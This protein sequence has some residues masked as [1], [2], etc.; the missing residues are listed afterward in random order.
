MALFSEGNLEA[1]GIKLDTKLR[2]CSVCGTSLQ[3]IAG[4]GYCCPNGH[5]CWWPQQDEADK[6]YTHPAA[7]YRGG[8]VVYKGNSKGRKR[9][10]PPR[11][12]DWAGMY[13]DS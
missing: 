9:K 5:G 7:V 11:K 3:Y 8:A 1:V 10:K 2:L 12:T 6:T 4:E 13:G